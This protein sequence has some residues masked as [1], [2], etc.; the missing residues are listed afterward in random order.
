MNKSDFILLFGDQIGYTSVIYYLLLP[1]AVI[2]YYL[3]PKKHRWIV[4][5]AAS[6]L[7]YRLLFSGHRRVLL[8]A[9]TILIS[10]ISGLLIERTR[11]SAKP[12]KTAALAMGIILSSLPLLLMD[13]GKMIISIRGGYGF[14][15]SRLI[16]PVGLSFYTLQMIAYLSD[17]YSGK[18]EAQ[19][20]F[21]KYTLFISFFPQILQGPIPRYKDLSYQLTDGNSFDPDN[22]ERGFQLILWG[23]FLKLMLADKAAVVVNTVFDNVDAYN[24]LYYLIAGILY[25][26]QLYADFLSCTTLSQGTA[27]LFGI[28]LSDNF[29]HPYFSTSIKDFW[30]RWHMSLSYWLR[31]YIYIPLGGNRKGK[32]RKYINLL[33]TFLV[34]GIWHGGTMKFMFWGLLHGIYQIIGGLTLKLRDRLW[35]SFGLGENSRLKRTFRVIGTSFLVMI[36]WIIFRADHLRTGIAMIQSIFTEFNPWILS[37]TY[38]FNLGLSQ[39]DWTVLILAT[40]LLFLISYLQ[41][42]KIVIGDHIRKLH[43]VFKYGVYLT[44]ILTVMIFGTYGFGFNASDFIYK[45]F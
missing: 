26:L 20:N 33:I 3:F 9:A 8:F 18:T 44:G 41:E 14:D 22:I 34:S 2:L 39:S 19:R 24:G 45:G 11:S 4:L 17:I 35:L 21:F 29:N 32:A 27:Y 43:V 37:G 28:K 42:K 38:L 5:L 15:I 40:L 7:F 36:A 6:A 16:I 30:R 10:W 31:D 25:S 23:F 13:A 1:V 12:K